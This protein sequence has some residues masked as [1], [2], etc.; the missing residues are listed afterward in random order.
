MLRECVIDFKGNCDDHQTLIEF[1]YNIV[2]TLSS[3]LLRMKLFMGEDAD[4][5]LD[6]L[7][8]VK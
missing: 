2:T 3:R 7:K 5:L 6:S 8:W 1:A 4:L